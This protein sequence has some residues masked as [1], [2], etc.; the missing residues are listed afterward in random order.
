MLETY[1]GKTML[2]INSEYLTKVNYSGAYQGKPSWSAGTFNC[3]Y[4]RLE[5]PSKVNGKKVDTINERMPNLL[6]V[7]HIK[8]SE[9]IEELGLQA[10]SRWTSLKSVKLPTTLKTVGNGAFAGCSTLK[11]IVIPN[12]VTF[13]GGYAFANC[14]NLEN[15]TI[16]DSVVNIGNAQSYNYGCTVAGGYT[17]SGCTSLK[18][19]YIPANVSEIGNSIFGTFYS[20]Q[21]NDTKIYCGATGPQSGWVS[22]WNGDGYSSTITINYGYTRE[23]YESA[24]AGN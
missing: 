6:N 8:V 3:D 24:I 2:T 13:I 4:T 14:S 23:A 1:D 17:F 16:P 20:G 21:Y 19:I 18:N 22:G 9:E 10:F 15:I 5:I 11:N 12:G 7:T